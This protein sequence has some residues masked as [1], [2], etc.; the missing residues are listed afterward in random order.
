MQEIN[1]VEAW[2]LASISK[3]YEDVNEEYIVEIIRNDTKYPINELL[4]AYKGLK[5]KG[6]LDQDSK[7]TKKSITFLQI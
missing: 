5:Q 4:L 1:E 3:P 6:Y 2:I 7:L